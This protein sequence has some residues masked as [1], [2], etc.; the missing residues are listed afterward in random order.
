MNCDSLKEEGK[1]KHF[2]FGDCNCFTCVVSPC[3]YPLD[4]GNLDSG[5]Y[6]LAMI[7]AGINLHVGY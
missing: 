4:R 1:C 5:S 3:G 6:T 2:H 7:I